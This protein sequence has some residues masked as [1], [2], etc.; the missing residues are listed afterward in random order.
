MPINTLQK[1]TIRWAVI[2]LA[3]T[4]SACSVKSEWIKLIQTETSVHYYLEKSDNKPHDGIL[5]NRMFSLY[6]YPTT[7]ITRDKKEIN[8]KSKYETV[9]IDCNRHL[10]VASD[11]EYY[12][13]TE[14][15]KGTEIYFYSMLPDKLEWRPIESDLSFDA[16]YKRVNNACN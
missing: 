2:I 4:S 1:T 8:Y 6:R 7:L 3:V 10:M 13:D 11:T 15:K 12:A 14:A 16:L 5:Y 9:M